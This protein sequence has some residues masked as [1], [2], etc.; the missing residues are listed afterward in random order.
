MPSWKLFPSSTIFI[1]IRSFPA[2]SRSGYFFYTVCSNS[3]YFNLIN[4]SFS[5]Y[6]SSEYFPYFSISPLEFPSPPLGFFPHQ[7]CFLMRIFGIFFVEIDSFR[8][9]PYRIFFL[10]ICLPTKLFYASDSFL[11]KIRSLHNYFS[12]NVP[13]WRVFTLRYHVTCLTNCFPFK[14]FPLNK[15]FLL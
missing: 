9:S 6:F 2:N 5:K 10:T 15:L 12:W 8:L 3:K 4:I 11:S 13:L 7:E 14:V 1:L